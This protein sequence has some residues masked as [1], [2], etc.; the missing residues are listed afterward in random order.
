MPQAYTIWLS[1]GDTSNFLIE[2][3]IQDFFK[4]FT[5]DLTS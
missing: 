5:I 3:K 2:E 1:G 4:I